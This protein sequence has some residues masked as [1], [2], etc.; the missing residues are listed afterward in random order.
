MS[1][2]K[3]LGIPKIKA[4]GLG[5]SNTDEK[6][7]NSGNEKYFVGANWAS[8]NIKFGQFA[9]LNISLHSFQKNT[10]M[11]V[12]LY[13]KNKVEDRLLDSKTL[14][15]N[16]NRLSVK[17]L[18][19]EDFMDL[20]YEWG[21]DKE[22]EFYC[23]INYL[24]SKIYAEYKNPL[25]LKFDLKT[26]DGCKPEINFPYSKNDVSEDNFPYTS[27]VF[28]TI[29]EISD[30]IKFYSQ[31]YKV[32]E[33][34]VAGAIADEYNSR[35]GWSK[36]VDWFQDDVLINWMPNFAIEFD[37]FINS[38]KKLLNS[39][40]H[41]LGIGNIKLE[42]AKELY[43]QYPQT[44][45][46]KNWDYTDLVDYVRSNDG[47]VHLATLVIKKAKTLFDSY[48]KQFKQEKQEAILVTYY[49]QGDSYYKKFIEKLKKNPNHQIG[50]GEGCRVCMQRDRTKKA[51]DKKI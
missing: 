48:I 46:K 50:S 24:N 4:L 40:K 22:L 49:K 17:F 25:I 13:E 11:T 8:R 33:I 43:N 21:E 10:K 15:V 45:K 20:F 38:N 31:L 44:F 7:I 35:K 14:Q 18:I 6:S 34:A 36:S 37:A 32:P 1:A 12:F 3:A 42:T 27:N 30:L 23:K 29:S 9:T 26:I 47:T 39:T 5:N 16:S 28:K 19:K 51:L 41:D 2:I